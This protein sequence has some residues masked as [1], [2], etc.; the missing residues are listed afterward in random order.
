MFGTVMAL[1]LA[2]GQAGGDE[3]QGPPG[4]T[5]LT[6][7]SGATPAGR[8]PVARGD[9]PEAVQTLQPTAPAGQ[10]GSGVTSYPASFFAP[11]QPNTVNDMLDHLPG[12]VFDDGDSVRGF[13]GAAGNVLIDGERPTSKNDDL[14]SVL[15]RIPI[16]QVERIDIIRGGAP[17]IDMQGKTVM[18]NV[19]RK[20]TAG[21]SLMIAVADSWISSDGRQEPAVRVE[22]S[23]TEGGKTLEGG[24]F[25]GSF[26]D[27]SAGDGPETRQYAT[28]ETQRL[29]DNT[30]AGGV[31]VT[32]TGA[33]TTPLLGGKFKVNGQL[34]GQSYLYDETD[35]D[36]IAADQSSLEHDHQNKEQGE[37]G[38]TYT[39]KFG[40]KL[41]V[42]TLYIQQLQGEDYLSLYY[43]PDDA[44]HFR[45]QHTNGESTLR[46]TVTYTASNSLT[47]EAGAEGA[48]NWLNSHTS[49]VV[50]GAQ[51]V[52]PAADVQVT[53]LRGEGFGK[54]TWVAS[55]QWT[56]EAGLRLE[57]SQIASAGDVVLQKTLFYPKPRLVASWSPTKVDQFRVRLEKEVGQLDFNDF[58]ASSS[59]STGQIHAGNP[60][61]D[62]QQASVI[63]AAYERRFWT[64][65][66]VSFTYRHSDLTD[67][68][69]RAP[70]FSPS[71]DYDA[72]A[73]IGKGR[74]DELI[75][76]VTTPLDPFGVPGGQLKAN[77]TWRTSRVLDPTTEVERSISGLRPRAGEIDFTQNLPK[78]NLNWGLTYYAGW[79]EAYY[80]FDQ[81]EVDTWR[82]N[83]SAFVEYRPIKTLAI[84]FELDDI[85]ADYRRNLEVFP[86]ARSL[87]AM[88][89]SAKRDLY[90]GPTPYVR[91]RRTF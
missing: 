80:R 3:P 56:F 72:P 89:Y 12:F 67:V 54:A 79:R 14:Y 47:F 40:D 37:L 5:P 25:V 20:T 43:A 91:I 81:I 41:S 55:P 76:A 17:G 2:A 57:G 63:E 77:Y 75:V 13:A 51:Q 32:A 18:A 26:N 46:S 66:D 73:N 78:W 33:Y 31:Q 7:Q 34:F 29:K 52:L 88:T 64:T 39:R 10:S 42:E 84:R 24:L 23:H 69:D 58:I 44:E 50:N 86:D 65:G 48:Y 6:A 71:G 15:R 61:L 19:I 1:A 4:A 68:V 83:G 59:L 60:N 70:V 62:P 49:Y 27:D 45:E 90:F 21:D 82:P 8:A 74:K 22:A 35:Q 53:E 11:F 36:R 28:G 87:T 16:A 85:S 30:E 9:K 38:L